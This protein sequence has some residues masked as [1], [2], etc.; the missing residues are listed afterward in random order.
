MNGWS[1]ATGGL[2]K[3]IGF[4]TGSDMHEAEPGEE[5]GD[6]PRWFL[7]QGF[8]PYGEAV[9]FDWSKGYAR[10]KDSSVYRTAPYIGL[11][12]GIARKGAVPTNV[13]YGAFWDGPAHW[14]QWEFN[15]NNTEIHIIL[16]N[17]RWSL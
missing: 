8:K 16:K 12:N 13:H 6:T 10:Y 5:Y 2:V 7:S 3:S 14:E 4:D 11:Y 9:S 15:K 1:N 17:E